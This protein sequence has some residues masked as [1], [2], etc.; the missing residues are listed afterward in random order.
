MILSNDFLSPKIYGEYWYDKP[1][2]YYWL[3]AMS[4]QV[5]GINDFAARFPSAFLSLL[6]IIAIYFYG[7]KL[8]NHKVE[9]YSALILVT[10]IEFFI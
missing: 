10:S 8:F 6:S 9:I 7:K 2:M 5:F 3:V 1:P 4:Y